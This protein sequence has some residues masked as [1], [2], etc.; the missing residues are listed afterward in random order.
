VTALA[1]RGLSFFLTA[2]R[3]AGS[4]GDALFWRHVWVNQSKPAAASRSPVSF[5]AQCMQWLPAMPHFGWPATIAME[6]LMHST[7]S[8]GPGPLSSYYTAHYQTLPGLYTVGTQ[9]T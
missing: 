3:R 4:D 6:A 2:V 8:A 1:K 5:T 9:H 7:V